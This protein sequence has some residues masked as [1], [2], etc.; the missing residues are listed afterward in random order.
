MKLKDIFR[1]ILSVFFIPLWRLESLLPRDERLWVFGSWFGWKYSDNSRA[2][3]EFMLAARPGYRCVWI[4]RSPSV[5]RRLAREKKPAAMANS[6]R[7]ITAC[8]RA[9]TGVVSCSG[10]DLNG[11]CLNGVRQIWL[12][13]GMPLKKIGYD[14]DSADLKE[15]P[16][17]AG[18][19]AAGLIQPW[20][21]PAPS[22]TVTSAPYFVPFLSSAFHLDEKNILP[23]GLP[24]CDKLFNPKRER[25]I[26]RIRRDYPQCAVLLYMPTF[27]TA[28][29]TNKAFDPFAGYNF[30]A[31]G[32]FKALEDCNIVF[33]YKPHFYDGGFRG[34][35]ASERFVQIGDSD[36]DDLYCLLGQIDVLTTDYSS[37]YFDFL[38]LGK[39]VIL[40][41][42]DYEEYITSARGLYSAYGETMEGVKAADWGELI[43]I[44]RERKYYAPERR[45]VLTY[46]RYNDGKSCEKVCRAL[47]SIENRD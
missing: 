23:T 47:A 17:K 1:K 42:F 28:S 46:A 22:I 3:Y 4:T 5:Y 44:L 37:V 45:T 2:L 43:Q 39:P 11:Y 26:E 34:K 20:N 6:L 21:R 24:R 14:D 41:P 16:A 19:K 10:L 25:L 31:G 30:D 13:H 8:L 36:Y 38:A 7:G 27:R 12:W 29:W 35:F 32:L 15:G 18:T 40:A 9:S 33:L